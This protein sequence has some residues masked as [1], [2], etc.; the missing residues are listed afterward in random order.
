MIKISK[1]LISILIF[2]LPIFFL[3]FFQNVLDFPKSLL[4]YLTLSL[5][6]L[7]YFIEIF[8]KGVFKISFNIF[9]L[10]AIF[11][12][13]F[14]LLSTIFSKSKIQ[15]F[16]GIPNTISESFLSLF[17]LFLFLFLFQEI[18]DQK[19]T[20]LLKTLFSLS[21][22]ILVIFSILQIYQKFIL[23]F[24]FSKSQIFTLSGTQYSLAILLAPLLPY[25]TFSFTLEKKILKFLYLI[26]IFLSL[27]FLSLVNS[28]I[29]WEIL[30]FSSLFSFSLYPFYKEN[31]TRLSLFLFLLYL[32]FGIS[33]LVINLQII[34]LQPPEI[35][36]GQELSLKI[37]LKS[38]RER[39]IF[40]SGPG[41]FSFNFSKYKPEFLNQTL[42]WNVRFFTSASKFLNILA[43]TGILGT[44]SFL[45]FLLFPIFLS[46]SLPRP[47]LFLPT[48]SGFIF[49]QFFY[50]SSL[51]FEFAYF[52][53][54]A[55]FLKELQKREILIQPTEK[56]FSF[57]F[58]FFLVSISVFLI[59][60]SIFSFQNLISEIYYFKGLENWQ[61][62]EIE[63]GVKLLERAR[64]INPRFDYY[65]RDLA[66]GYLILVQQKFQ[67]NEPLIDEVSSLVNNA[68]VATEKEKENVANWSVLGFVYQNLIGIASGAENAAI[69]TWEKA[70]QLEPSNPYFQTQ[71]GRALRLK[72]DLDEAR[73]SFEKAISLKPDY[74]PAHFEMALFHQAKGEL[75]MAI[76]KLRETQNLIPPDSILD[77]IGV[78][79]QLGL[80]YYQK[81]DYQMAKEEL[82]KV[83]SLSPDYA[84]ALYFLGLSYD[85]LGEKEKAIEKFEKIAQLNPENEEVKKILKNLKEGKG[86]LEE[87]S[88]PSQ[89]PVEEK[90]PE[91][92]EKK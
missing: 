82:E 11:F 10:P 45:F 14:F 64:Q 90:P 66:Q 19:E 85:K 35:T 31:F 48:L 3:P 34:T 59:F 7:F 73:K 50:P 52:F 61:K 28:K 43:T 58:S 6:G 36:L 2:L 92:K 12:L 16:V 37:A 86:A 25:F 8:K 80:V 65:F 71:R 67:K 4:L 57:L 46:F 91:I 15:S 17:F 42:L 22:L 69:N 20:N 87:I 88:P 40:G 70:I 33:F 62:G 84:N 18:F 60:I 41:T 55:L 26:L 75:D 38:L 9:Y 89:P 74:A 76:S 32:S 44:L 24:G 39:P 72:G 47:S 53:F 21:I 30:I 54:L 1:I 23:P 49:A 81:G 56:F 5:A 79:F 13:I 29:A 78:G 27:F 63:K 68:K 51:S 77:R 83:I